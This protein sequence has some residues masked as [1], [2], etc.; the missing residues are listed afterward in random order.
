[1]KDNMKKVD[2]GFSFLIG[3]LIGFGITFTFVDV[4]IN[5]EITDLEK[6]KLRIEIEIKKNQLKRM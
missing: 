5:K 3:L 1:M 2:T 6:E 4:L